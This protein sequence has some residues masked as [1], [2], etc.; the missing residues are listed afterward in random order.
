MPEN[1]KF[2]SLLL[3]EPSLITACGPQSLITAINN[4]LY[5]LKVDIYGTSLIVE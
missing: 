2:E 4:D 5:K 3:P 1:K